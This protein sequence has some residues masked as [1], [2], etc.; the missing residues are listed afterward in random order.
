MWRRVVWFYIYW[1]EKAMPPSA[2]LKME[3]VNSSQIFI[4]LIP[5]IENNLQIL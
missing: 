2:G 3:P 1:L 5:Y 4:L